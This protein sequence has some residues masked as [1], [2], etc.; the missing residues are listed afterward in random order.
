MNQ[1]EYNGWYNY[2]TWLVNLWLT[3]DQGSY[4]YWSE[5]TNEAKDVY[6]LSNRIK[7]EIEEF[8]PVT[9]ESSLYADLMN[10]AI[11]EVN[12]DEIAR[13]FFDDFREDSDEE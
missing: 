2:E 12:F 8:N 1:N 6:E 3:N 4:N 11:S 7:D 10:A 5:A 9:D 13:S